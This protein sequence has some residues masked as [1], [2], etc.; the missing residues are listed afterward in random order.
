MV[1]KFSPYVWE[2]KPKGDCGKRVA[3]EGHFRIIRDVFDD[4]R[5]AIDLWRKIEMS[6]LLTFAPQVS[7]S[8][9]PLV[10]STDVQ[11]WHF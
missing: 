3:T 6:L 8:C 11:M 1:Q 4:V 10:L 7:R 2:G 9:D 5:D